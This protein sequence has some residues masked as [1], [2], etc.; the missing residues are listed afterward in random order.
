MNDLGY[1]LA[2]LS[3]QVAC[4]L[5]PALV[6]QALASRRGPSS[7]A[8]VATWSLGLTAAL[9][10]AA[11]LF[12]LG[13]AW[14]PMRPMASSPPAASVPEGSR[15]GPLIM[16][17]RGGPERSVSLGPLARRWL[18]AWERLGHRVTGPAAMVRPWGRVFALVTL[19]GMG[20]GL[21]RLMLGLW[22]VRLCRRQGTPVR[23]PSMTAL[24]EQLRIV[25]RCRP[26]VEVLEVPD[27]ASPATAGL[28]RPM[29]LFPT[30]WRRWGEADRRAV[31]A[32]E[33]AHV[34]RGDY[35]AGLLARVAVAL[36]FLHP[37]VRWMA[38]WL[39]LE[40]ELAADAMGA[41]FAGGRA[42]Y[43]LALSR[44]ALEQDG[45]PSSWP[46][47]AFLP[48]RGTL[49][50][51]IAML[52]KN[53]NGSRRNAREWS[54]P[55]RLTAAV[56]L[57][58]LSAGVASWKA[59]AR[60]AENGPSPTPKAQAG[61]AVRP[62]DLTYV[63]D[64][65]K[66]VAAV[67]PAAL[68]SRMGVD[69]TPMIEDILIED[70]TLISKPLGV[71]P[72]R[73]GF[74]KIRCEDV[75][76]VVVG[77]NL[78]RSRTRGDD[79]QKLHALE[80]RGLTVRTVE[81]FDWRGFFRQWNLELSEVR[82]SGGVYYKIKNTRYAEILMGCAIYL[83]DDRT[84]VFES[85]E[86]IQAMIAREKPTAPDY[87][88]G[89]DWERAS[90]GVLAVAIDNRNDTFIKSFGVG[91]PDDAEV[92]ALFKGIDRWV[93]GVGGDDEIAILGEAVGRDPQAAE[94]V[95]RAVEGLVKLGR[96]A[97]N[98][99]SP[100]SGGHDLAVRLT[101]G[102]LANLKVGHEGR[103][104][105]LSSEEFGTFADLASFFLVE[106]EESRAKVQTVETGPKPVRR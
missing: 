100:E 94:A 12:G 29:L 79:G 6:L 55:K 72:S 35:A 23:D 62:F 85:E 105:S 60:A 90:R 25:M 98:S 47:R 91:R 34:I 24:V 82:K 7:G 63:P 44:L 65:V 83:P 33:L 27:L 48:A 99:A 9:G 46:V 58:V 13:P 68:A 21:L 102:L 3:L 16:P 5:A 53:G 73:P 61:E 101:K 52:K 59:P 76:S 40:Q 17:E 28:W 97:L 93:F 32:H 42:A 18:R 41:R 77:F 4:L 96:E 86:T 74:V 19:S 43:L 56:G 10:F 88:R 20:L 8:W 69:L 38:G 80:F 54:K 66:G 81:P 67:R 50:R 26:E 70:I 36:N 31:V 89:A 14:A 45:R 103:T 39:H 22:A 51:R 75:E 92:L 78:G 84:I 2:W 37:L 30:D 49:I 71:D 87:L 1:A 104:I 64:T 95:A 106:I 15:A 57:L 11:V